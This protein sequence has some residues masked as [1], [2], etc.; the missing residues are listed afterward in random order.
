[1]SIAR[2]TIVRGPAVVKFNSAV[3]FAKGDIS[4]DHNI[5]TFD[6][7]T[8]M[9]GK[10][11]ERASDVDI[12]VSFDPV[13]EWENLTVLWPYRTSLIGSSIF[14]TDKTL[15]IATLAGQVLTYGA[16]GVVQMP[17]INLSTQKTPIGGVKFKC[18][19]QDNTAWDDNTNKL[20]SIASTA[21]LDADWAQFDVTK[22][23]TQA[24]AF[25][26]GSSPWNAIKTVEGAT[27]NFDLKIDPVTSDEDGKVDYTLGDVG[28][29]VK[30]T[31]IGLTEQNVIDAMKIQATG[32][33]KRGGT[34]DANANDFVATGTNVS[35]TIHKAALKTSGY[36]FGATTLR[37]GELGF[38]SSRQFTGGKSDPIWTIA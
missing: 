30:L 24:F 37:L 15:V 17:D 32:A 38:V 36:R 4:V 29:M 9:H 33:I 6:V 27:I 26:W 2:A 23:Y 3:F 12:D 1:M 14:G 7:M 31:P 25:A 21:F 5:D 20:L 35:A 13:G 19:R 8:S 11:S 22:I 34:I 28:A 18:L 10:V 16:A